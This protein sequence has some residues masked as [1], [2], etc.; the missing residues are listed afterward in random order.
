MVCG[1]KGRPG[2]HTFPEVAMTLAA[3]GREAEQV[4][5]DMTSRSL[6]AP[7][8]RRSASTDECADRAHA[9]RRAVDARSSYPLPSA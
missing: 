6:C 1:E 7:I 8:G 3:A 4:D 5:N 2:C 9:F